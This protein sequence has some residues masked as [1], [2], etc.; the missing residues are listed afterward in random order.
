[1]LAKGDI[2]P[3]FKLKGND[4]R[5]Y[6]LSEFKGRKVVLI[7]YPADF[8]PTCTSEHACFR[9]DLQAFRNADAVVFGISVDSRWSHKAFAKEMGLEYPLLADFMPR[10]AV[11]ER[12]GVF[13]PEAGTSGR[14]TFVIGPDGRV[15]EA[16]GYGFPEVP[17][18]APVLSV[19]DAL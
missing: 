8:S 5:E 2:A 12:Y 7:F 19:L 18:T 15:A 17:E 10:G 16:F 11:A 14:A 6:T 13:Y 4:D 1:M 9:D 3:D